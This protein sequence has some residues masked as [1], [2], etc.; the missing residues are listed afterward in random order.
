VAL[1]ERRRVVETLRRLGAR[2]LFTAYL[3]N[4][5]LRLAPTI[6]DKLVLGQES[7]RHLER[8]EML[9]AMFEGTGAGELLAAVRKLLDG[10]PTPHTWSELVVARFLLSVAGC[11][12]LDMC[13]RWP[14][15]APFVE[16]V[17][18]MRAVESEHQEVARATLLDLAHQGGLRPTTA[19]IDVERWTRTILLFFEGPVAV[20]SEKPGDVGQTFAAAVESTLVACGL[21]VPI[22][23][24]CA[25]DTPAG[26]SAH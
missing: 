12:Q 4:G 9:S 15:E 7:L 18:R 16:A 6:D 17:Q 25:R 5:G 11:V 2:E 8:F 26:A 23:G 10:C 1:P 19:Q 20:A 24:E 3:L 21:R 13:K 22:A 14:G